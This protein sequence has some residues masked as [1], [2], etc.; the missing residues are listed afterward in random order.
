MSEKDRFDWNDDVEFNA[1]SDAIEDVGCFESSLEG[2]ED[3]DDSSDYEEP[4]SAD[5]PADDA[6]GQHLG[7][8]PGH[9]R[10]AAL[11]CRSWFGDSQR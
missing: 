1:E 6:A 7:T 2:F 10:D 11:A 9:C 4:G 3:F 5:A 8:D